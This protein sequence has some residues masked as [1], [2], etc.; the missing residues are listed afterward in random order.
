MIREKRFRGAPAAGCTR[1]RAAAPACAAAASPSPAPPTHSPPP[2]S[3]PAALSRL[4]RRL[5]A[6]PL[7]VPPPLL[8]LLFCHHRR[9]RPAV[10]AAGSLA[11]AARRRRR[12]R[13]RGWAASPCPMARVLVVEADEKTPGEGLSCLLF[14]AHGYSSRLGCLGMCATCPSTWQDT[15]A[16]WRE[17]NVSDFR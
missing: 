8:L 12:R 1:P 7:M 17:N 11:C 4:P 5:S 13:G 14:L 3:S 6:L 9:R 10:D 16:T 15:H 2:P